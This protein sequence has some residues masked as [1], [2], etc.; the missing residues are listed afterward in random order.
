MVEQEKWYSLKEIHQQKLLPMLGSEYLIRQAIKSGRL[1]AISV[2]KGKGKRYS[3]KGLWIVS[4]IA[5]FE[6]GSLR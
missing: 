5:R 2:G 1:K 4:F 6:T 3:I